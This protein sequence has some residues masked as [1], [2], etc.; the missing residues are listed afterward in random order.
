MTLIGLMGDVHGNP[1]AVAHGLKLFQMQGITTVV[2][3]GDFGFWPGA[4]GQSYLS[5]VSE[6]LT[7]NDQYLVVVPGNHEDYNQLKYLSTDED[8]WQSIRTRIKVAPRGHR[9]TWDEVSFVALG[10]APSVDR[11]YRVAQQKHT[12]FPLWWPEEAITDEDVERTIEGGT[13]DVMF[14]HDA[15]FGV[16]QIENY[17][18]PNPFN[19]PR[20]DLMYA[21]EGR[22]RMRQAVEAVSPKMFF[23]GHYH[24]VFK[25]TLTLENSNEVLIRGLNAD[26]K[27]GTYAILDLS[28]LTFELLG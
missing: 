18:A 14:A 23:H 17:I 6:H 4:I 12:S 24:K 16:S 27:Y 15:P 21:K 22:E 25:D 2:Q 10:G 7:D 26:G 19:F 11:T 3:L 13:A 8:G 20:Q 5:S 1:S 9:W 28:D